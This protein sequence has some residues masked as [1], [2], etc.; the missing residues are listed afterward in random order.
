MSCCAQDLM[1]CERILS[2]PTS[3]LVHILFTYRTFLSANVIY[4]QNVFIFHC[5]NITMKNET[6]RKVFCMLQYGTWYP[7][8]Y[9]TQ[10]NNNKI[11]N[12]SHKHIKWYLDMA[13]LSSFFTIRSLL[14]F[15]LNDERK[16]SGFL[17]SALLQLAFLFTFFLLLKKRI[18]Y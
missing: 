13:L 18:F 1:Q 9:T 15:Y 10:Q 14:L 16:L 4:R 3:S 11:K 5:Q 2:F 17:D 7:N 6:I 8:K 12:L